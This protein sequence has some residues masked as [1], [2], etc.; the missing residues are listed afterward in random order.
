MTNLVS[1]DTMRFYRIRAL[2]LKRRWAVLP[3]RQEELFIN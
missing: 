2:V 3:A 1:T